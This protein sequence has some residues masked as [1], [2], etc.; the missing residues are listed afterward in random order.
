MLPEPLRPPAVKKL[1]LK[2]ITVGIVTYSQP[3][4]EE[5]MRKR[6]INMVDCV[7]VLRGGVAKE[8]EYEN[9][10][11]RYQI[12]TPMMCVVVRFETESML[13]VVTAWRVK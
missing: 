6:R 9:G 11:W 3:H 7:N 12:C 13:E 1:I 8:G 4:A 10:S 2:I 5:Q